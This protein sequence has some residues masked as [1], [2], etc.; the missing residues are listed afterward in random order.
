[1]S[2]LQCDAYATAQDTFLGY[3]CNTKYDYSEVFHLLNYHFNNV[4]DPYVPSL[5]KLNTKE[6]EQRVLDFF[7]ELWHFKDDVWGYITHNGTEG[8]MQALYVA[9]QVFPGATLLCSEDSHYSIFKIAKMLQIKVQ[10]VKS[11]ENGEIDYRH[12]DQ[13]IDDTGD[14]PVIV[15]ANMGSTMKG[16]IDDARELYRILCKYNKDDKYYM[17]ADGALMGFVLPFLE[18]D[19]FF[20]KCIHSISISGHKFLGVPFPCGIFMMARSFVARIG[21][22]VEY[23]G[24]VDNTIS[25]SRNGHSAAFIDYI[26]CQKGIEGFRADIMECLDV[27]EYLLTLLRKADVRAWRNNNSITVVFDRPPEWVVTKWQ[28]ASQGGLSHVVVMPH[29]TRDKVDRF[30]SDLSLALSA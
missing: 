19:T 18:T 21:S 13:C 28:L 20:K 16:A 26:I 6:I 29:V 12:F 24:S 17:H 15:C 10:V 11:N 1:M 14:S 30:M 5:Y 25:G 27:S 8:N 7:K 23:I 22:S 2:H 4:G 9:R 3:P